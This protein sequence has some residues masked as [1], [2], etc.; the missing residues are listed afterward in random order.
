MPLT[1]LEPGDAKTALEIYKLILRFTGESGLSGWQEQMLG[2]YIVE[3]GQSQ[4]ALRDE[5]LA[6]LAYHTWGVQKERDSLRGWLLLAC[7][8][9]AFVPSPTL[10]K[11]LLKYVSDHGPMEYRSLCQHKMLTSLQLSTPTSRIYPPTQLE[12]TSSQRKGTMV[13]DLHTFNDEKLTTEVESWTTGEQLASWLLHFRGVSEAVEGWSVTLLTDEGWS[14]LAGSDF[15]MDLLAGAETEKLPPLGTLSSTNSDYLFSSHGERMPTTDMDDIIPPAPPVKAP[16][17]PPFEGS[18]WGFDHPQEGMTMAMPSYPMGTSVHPQ[19]P[20]YGAAPMMSTMPGMPTMPAMMTL[21]PMPAP[22]VIDPFQTAATQ[23]AVINQ[24]ACLMAQQMTMQ[25]MSLSQQQ[26]QEQRQKEQ[27]REL[28]KERQRQQKLQSDQFLKERSPSPPPVQTKTPTTKYT[29]TYR[30]PEPEPEREIVL[31]DP[32]D[33]HSFTD[34]KDYF[35]KIVKGPL[36][37]PA[38]EAD[39][40]IVTP[41]EP[42]VKPTSNIREIIKQYNSRTP[43]EPKPFEPVRPPARHFAKKCD[44]K[45]EALAKL[46]NKAPMPEQIKCVPPP[47]PIEPEIEQPSLRT[48]PSPPSNRGPHIISSSMKQ[49]QRS[50]IDLFGSQRSQNPLPDSPPPPPQPTSIQPDIPDPPA[51]AAPSLYMMPDE[52]SIQSQLQRFSAGVFFSYSDMLGKLFMRK[53]VFYPKE[54]FNQPYILNLLCEQIMRDTYSDS[55]M[56]ISREERRKMKD[57]LANFSVGTTISTIQDDNMKKRIIIAAR[58][59]WENYFSRLFPVMSMSP[60]PDIKSGLH[61]CSFAELLSVD[62]Q[63]ADKVKL[64]LKSENVVMQSTRAPQITAMIRLFLQEIIKDSGHVIALKSF[65]TDDKSLLSFCKGDIIKL[66]PMEG[67]QTALTAITDTLFKDEK[68]GPEVIAALFDSQ[69]GA[70]KCSWI[71]IGVVIQDSLI[72]YNDPEINELSVQCFMN[73]MQFMGDRQLKKKTT[74]S[75]CLRQILLLGKEKELLRDEI[76]CQVI[77]Q[78]TNNSTKYVMFKAIPLRENEMANVCLD[79]LQRSLSFGGRRNIPSHIEMK[80]LLLKKPNQTTKKE[81]ITGERPEIKEYLPPQLDWFRSQAEEIQSFCLGQIAAMQSLSPQEAKIRFVEFMSRLPLF[82]FNTYLAKTVSQHGC[83]SPCVVSISEEGML[84]LHPKT[85][86]QA[87]MIPLADVQAMCTIRPKRRGKGPAVNINYGNPAHPKN[88]TIYLKQTHS[89]KPIDEMFMFLNYLALGSN[90]RDLAEQYGTHQSTVSRIIS[91]WSHFLYTVL[92]AV[93]IWIPEEK[94]R[95]HLPT[96]FK[97]CADTTVILDCTELRCQCPSSPL[98]QSEGFSANTS[99]CALRGLLG[100]APHGAVTFIS[101]LYAG[102]ISDKQITRESGI[103]SLLTPGM[104]IMVDRGF[105][106]ADFVQCKIYGPAFLSGRFQMSAREVRETQAIARLRVHV[107]RLISRVKEHKFFDAEIPLRL[108][109]SIN[110]LYAVACLLTHYE[111]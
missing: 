59:N 69:L 38:R 101:P 99:H 67:L 97:D 8:L 35:Q 89:L 63:D 68:N 50:L 31:P 87:F 98:L 82:G 81:T 17:L 110:Q 46:K 9:S 25:A 106:V 102:S 70:V 10:D 14:D 61:E 20:S 86:E 44:P 79:N 28:D 73:L 71:E 74:Q 109:G 15:V 80:A 13:L 48:Q 5:I 7:C 56:R 108:F 57:L 95:E 27:E 12:W 2:N 60:R 4:P 94:I 39:P 16:G 37:P 64:E 78:T 24:Q 23:Q 41:T 51:M 76:Y 84:F 42:H 18:L 6:Q 22:P 62:L 90:R 83:P 29:S 21:A 45:E 30:Q 88:V 91:T 53:E 111:N 96:E 93:R 104:A 55:C 65:V 100:I 36:V 40:P 11:P 52:E 26:I 103:L 54:M 3:K 75:D 19:M 33:L 107:E 77:K 32:D 43:P 105:H 92:G 72:F 49:K 66:L 34:K 47:P 58:D 1:S 85:Q